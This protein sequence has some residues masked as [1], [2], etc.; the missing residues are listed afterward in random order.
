MFRLAADLT[1]FVAPLGIRTIVAYV[2]LNSI[3]TN[4]SVT[5][6]L[7]LTDATD[8]GIPFPEHLTIFEMISNGYVMAVIILLSSILQ[9]TFSQ[10]STFLVNSEG[11]HLKIALQV[12]LLFL[13]SHTSKLYV[14]AVSQR[15]IVPGTCHCGN[16]ESHFDC[17]LHRSASSLN[18]SMI[19]DSYHIYHVSIFLF[20]AKRRH[21][22]YFYRL[23][24]QNS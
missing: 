19:K 5:M 3:S 20:K 8:T 23:P 22:N 13:F 17:N 10:C 21:Y 15:F 12:E 18:I 11:I 14:C 16:R 1:G 2:K 9:S 7:S 4:S 6:E 24:I